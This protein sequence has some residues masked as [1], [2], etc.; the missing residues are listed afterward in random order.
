[1]TEAVQAE[2]QAPAQPQAAPASAANAIPEEDKKWM[3][4]V[5]ALQSLGFLFGITFIAAVIL[6]MI[7]KGDMKSD[8]GVSHM[9]WATRTF[10]WSLGWMILASI[11]MPFMGAGLIVAIPAGIWTLYRVIRGW[12]AMS[13][14]KAL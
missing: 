9:S 7:K 10:W 6:S 14:G 5:Y 3:T 2:N 4:I 8:I 13:G 11:L 1:M 12:V